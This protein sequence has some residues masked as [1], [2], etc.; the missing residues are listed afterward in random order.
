[1]TEEQFK[2]HFEDL[3]E[4]LQL[5]QPLVDEF[6]SSYGYQHVDP[7]SIGR[8]PRIRIQKQGEVAR[9]L[10]LSMELDE[11]GNRYEIF[12]DEVPYELAA[13][14]NFHIEDGTQYGHRFQKSFAVFSGRPFKAVPENLLEDLRKGAEEIEEW[15]AA[16]LKEHGEKVQL[17]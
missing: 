5:V 17:G 15:T 6:C 7:R 13:G 14:A 12:F 8:Y 4:H 10:D 11:D 9:W 3:R 1:M 16:M 2:K